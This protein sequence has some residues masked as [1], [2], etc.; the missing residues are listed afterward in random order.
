MR[1][2]ELLYVSAILLFA[3]C[4]KSP[5]TPVDPVQD[6][7]F[8]WTTMK[9]KNITV[10]E[11]SDVFNQYGDTIASNL[12]PGTYDLKVGSNTEVS[13]LPST[14]TKADASTSVISFPSAGKYATVMVEDIYPNMGDYDFN[15]MVFG[16]R[17][18]FIMNAGTNKVVTIKFNILPAG[19]GSSYDKLGIAAFFRG[20]VIALYPFNAVV[21]TPSD[22]S[23]LFSRIVESSD[24]G[25]VFPLTGNFRKHFMKKGADGAYALTEDTYRG[26]VNTQNFNEYYKGEPFTVS[27]NIGAQAYNTFDLFGTDKTKSIIDLFVVINERG[28][29]I[30]FKGQVP[31]SFNTVSANGVTDYQKDGYVWMVLMDTP[32]QYP[33]EYTSIE[34]AYPN[35]TQWAKSLGTT[36]TDWYNYPSKAFDQSLVN[37]VERTDGNVLYENPAQ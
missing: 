7:D 23:D 4:V 35:F 32:K 25:L 29:E 11:T 13:V 21:G 24:N 16:L 36:N 17:I 18:D 31:S 19:A 3:G 27:I 20:A 33:V 10:T 8:N 34:T 9:T 28:K 37:T 1:K 6:S 12:A 2:F 5:D 26:F 22:Y 30:H 15:D 14:A